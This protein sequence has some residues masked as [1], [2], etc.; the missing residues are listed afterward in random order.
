MLNLA[1]EEF[2]TTVERWYIPKSSVRLLPTLT[3]GS[4]LS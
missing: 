4:C 1:M 2:W 3:V